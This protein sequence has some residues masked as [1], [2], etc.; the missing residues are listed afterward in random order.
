VGARAVTER[1]I[2]LGQLRSAQPRFASRSTRTPQRGGPATSPLIVPATHTLATDAQRACDRGLHLTHGEQARSLL[3]AL[4]QCVEVSSW[5]H[6]RLHDAIIR[7]QL[8]NVTI[9]CEIH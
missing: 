8:P 2:D 5:C 3:A 7:E 4:S 1:R 9:L 6:S